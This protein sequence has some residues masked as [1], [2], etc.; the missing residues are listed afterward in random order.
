M[1]IV[2]PAYEP[3][4]HLV[5]M[6]ENLIYYTNYPIVI[7]NDGSSEDK[8]VIF[9]R[10]RSFVDVINHPANLG[11]GEAMKT[12]LK[13]IQKQFPFEDGVVFI[14][15]DGQ[16]S[17]EDMEKVIEAFYLNQGAL[18]IG[19]REFT[20]KIPIKS[21]IGNKITRLIFKILSKVAVSDTQTGLRA[22]STKY[23]PMLLEIEGERYEYEMNM[24]L[25]FAKEKI[26]IAEV[27]IETIYE[28]SSN[29]TSHFRAV[30]D[31]IRIYSVI[32]K[33]MTSSAVSAL[34]DYVLFIFLISLFAGIQSSLSV[35]VCNIFARV[36]SAI[37]NYNLNKK[38]VFKSNNDN[39]SYGIKYA[40][41]AIGIL[42][43]NSLILYVLTNLMFIPAAIAKIVTEILLFFVSFLI[44]Q[45]FIFTRKVNQQS[46]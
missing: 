20:G 6:V 14:D 31:S 39:R 43:A 13:Y 21:L 1:V 25:T 40:V 45:R 33:F 38:C 46:I 9:D 15:A 7:V 17:I 36:V 8:K 26:K 35:I 37:T 10:L 19:S 27:S 41:L 3:D 22:V 29:S 5:K 44:Q 28:D 2:I 23:I 34:L 4:H 12:G 18:I 30:K 16:H 24:L 42:C 11:K 32:F